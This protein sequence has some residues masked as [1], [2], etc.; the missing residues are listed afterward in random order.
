[1][2]PLHIGFKL[3]WF[4]VPIGNYALP[5]ANGVLRQRQNIGVTTLFGHWISLRKR[6]WCGHTCSSGRKSGAN[7]IAPAIFALGE[8]SFNAFA[9]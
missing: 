3:G 6:Y 9:A 7:E 2:T 4:A 1:L 8:N 5:Q